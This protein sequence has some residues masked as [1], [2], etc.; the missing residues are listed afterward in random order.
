MSPSKKQRSLKR[1]L[2]FLISKAE[3]GE[4]IKLD[5]FQFM[6]NMK[7]NISNSFLANRQFSIIATVQQSYCDWQEEGKAIFDMFRKQKKKYK[8]LDSNNQK[9]KVLHSKLEPLS[10]NETRNRGFTHRF[11]MDVIVQFSVNQC[12]VKAY[13]ESDLCRF[14]G[15]TLKSGERLYFQI[16]TG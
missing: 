6:N 13:I 1:L 14:R 5:I 15:I 12:N 3:Q 16:D 9:F 8:M 11:R 2:I 7:N 4:K 10:I